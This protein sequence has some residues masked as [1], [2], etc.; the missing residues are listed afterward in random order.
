MVDKDILHFPRF[1]MLYS[2][3]SFLDKCA[4]V[5]LYCWSKLCGPGLVWISA[6][7]EPGLCV[8]WVR[9]FSDH[10]FNYCISINTM[11]FAYAFL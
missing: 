6:C 5:D 10:I 2:R 11:N 8:V 1:V 9:T 4:V 3:A 7:E